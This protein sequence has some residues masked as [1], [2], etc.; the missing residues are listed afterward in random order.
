MPEPRQANKQPLTEL[1][2]RVR[3][4]VQ[5]RLARFAQRDAAE[6]KESYLFEK[7]H[8]CGIRFSLGPFRA[9]WR[10]NQNTIQFLRNGTEIGQIEIDQKESRRAA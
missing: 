5:S 2:I 3:K 10:T 1:T 9:T 6:C 7:D 4:L 8:F